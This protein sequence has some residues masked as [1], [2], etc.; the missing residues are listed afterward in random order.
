MADVTSQI[1]SVQRKLGKRVVEAGEA[2]TA[3][4][5]QVYDTGID[6]LW[7]ACTDPERIP[8]WFLP[9]SGDLRAGG[10]YQLEGN[11]G[12]TIERCDPPKSFAA[13]WEYG[14]DVSWIEVRLSPEADG[15]TRFELDHTAVPNEHWNQFGPGAV[16]IG[17][18]MMLNGLALHLESGEAADPEAAMAWMTSEEGVRFMTLSNEAWYEADVASGTGAATART[19]ADAT[20]AAYTAPPES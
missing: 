5:S 4:V 1:D 3:T 2:V 15:R 18:D 17:W 7:N 14:G 8:R 9:V 11:A 6:D 19:R 20:L 16:G 13:T 12:G 10:K